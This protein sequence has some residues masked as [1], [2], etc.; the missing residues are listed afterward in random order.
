MADQLYYSRSLEHRTLCIR[1]SLVFYY[2][3]PRFPAVVYL[4][5]SRINLLPRVLS[6]PIFTVQ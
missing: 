5:G 1:P 2:Y 3:V 6:D 4:D